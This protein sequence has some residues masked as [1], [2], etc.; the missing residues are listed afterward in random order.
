V[1]ALPAISMELASSIDQFPIGIEDRDCRNR[2]KLQ[3]RQLCCS[4]R[5][6]VAIRGKNNSAVR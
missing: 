2:C 1:N 5:L 4:V 6:L 3:F